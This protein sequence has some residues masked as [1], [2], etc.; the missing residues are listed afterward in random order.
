ME[1]KKMK[2]RSAISITMMIVAIVIILFFVP[3]VFIYGKMF[4]EFLISSGVKNSPNFKDGYLIAEFYDP[5]Y[6]AILPLPDDTV[7]KDA[8]TALDI[9][10]FSVKKV[11]FRPLS[12]IGLD[13]RLNLC[14][15]FDGKQPNPFAFK[16]GFSFP[17]I[18]V[19]FKTPNANITRINS[20]KIANANFGEERWNYQVIID[21]IH[22]QARVFDNNG[23]FL[24][25]GLGIYVNYDYEKGKEKIIAR[26]KITAGLPL[27]LIGDPADGEW[28]YYVATGL[29]DV[30]NP[31]MLYQAG[32][33]SANIFDY[34]A[35]DTLSRFKIDSFGKLS[36]SPLIVNYSKSQK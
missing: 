17:V 4:E 11:K 19:Y 21:G 3:L 34:V 16:N 24:F 1:E 23:K 10:K 36:F 20:D 35:S 5:S 2:Y 28:K 33:D 22:E 6:D 9:R 26:T 13:D 31:S 12:G 14:F 7:Y 27:E 8:R 30:K 18:H 32:K 15:D 25:N 29:L